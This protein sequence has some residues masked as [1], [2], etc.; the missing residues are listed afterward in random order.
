MAQGSLPGSR[1]SGP[2]RS[3]STNLGNGK[4]QGRSASITIAA[5]AAAATGT[6]TIAD[7]NAIVGD[8]ICVSP[9]AAM[10]AGAIIASARVTVD[11][12]IE[13]CIVNASGSSLVGGAKTLYYTISA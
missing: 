13:V 7:S 3:T 8:V 6:Y 12:T 11:G 1:M 2:I 5:L 4:Q 9:A 10:E